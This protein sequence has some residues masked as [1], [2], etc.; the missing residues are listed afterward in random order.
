MCIEKRREWILKC[1]KIVESGFKKVENVFENVF[2]SF[3][4]AFS[5]FLNPHALV[6][7]SD[8]FADRLQHTYTYPDFNASRIALTHHHH[9]TNK[10]K[11]F[12][13]IYPLGGNGVRTVRILKFACGCVDCYEDFFEKTEC[14]KIRTISILCQCH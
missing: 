1:F 4:N 6:C 14:G 2:K 8:E 7:K 10:T 9:T 13:L 5:T 11:Q 3:L 12:D